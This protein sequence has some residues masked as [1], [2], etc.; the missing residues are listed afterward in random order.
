MGHDCRG[1]ALNSAPEI[2]FA[3]DPMILPRPGQVDR[4][5]LLKATSLVFIERQGWH[6]K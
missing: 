3:L 1:K 5:A 6:H 2:Q 4:Y